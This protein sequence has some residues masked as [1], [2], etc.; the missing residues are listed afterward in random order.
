MNLAAKGYRASFW[1]RFGRAG[2]VEVGEVSVVVQGGTLCFLRGG[3]GVTLSKGVDN[4][5]RGLVIVPELDR[6]WVM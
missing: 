4:L 3:G 2:G 5:T 1:E 6:H